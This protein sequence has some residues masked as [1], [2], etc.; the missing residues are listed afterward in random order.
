MNLKKKE[1]EG[2][3]D[4]VSELSCV[5]VCLCETVSVIPI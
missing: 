3:I 5:S 1:Q 4:A 2:E